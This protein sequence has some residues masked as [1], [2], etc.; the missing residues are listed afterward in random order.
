METDTLA[1]LFIAIFVVLGRIRSYLKKE[2]KICNFK[3]FTCSTEVF[4]NANLYESE[5]RGAAVLE[6]GDTQRLVVHPLHVLD[7]TEVLEAHQ[8]VGRG[9]R[10][11]RSLDHCFHPFLSSCTLPSVFEN[12]MYP[13]DFKGNNEGGKWWT[14]YSHSVDAGGIATVPGERNGVQ[15]DLNVLP[16][17]VVLTAVSLSSELVRATHGGAQRVYKGQGSI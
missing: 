6:L 12:F 15:V 4:Q 11:A 14:Q 7:E 5:G 1:G 9:G 13:S 3:Y 2:P 8:A 17:G 16:A 10:D